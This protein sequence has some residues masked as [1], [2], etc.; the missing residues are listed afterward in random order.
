V[1]N[2]PPVVGFEGLFAAV[3]GAGSRCHAGQCSVTVTRVSTQ[4][5]LSPVETVPPLVQKSENRGA[6]QS[7]KAK[8][9]KKKN[10]KKKKKLGGGRKIRVKN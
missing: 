3:S 10:Q 2:L 6:R 8:R 4:K 5:T 7:E 1:V 9:K